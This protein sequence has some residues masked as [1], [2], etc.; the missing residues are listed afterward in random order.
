MPTDQ[1]EYLSA[2]GLLLSFILWLTAYRRVH[3][4]DKE[5]NEVLPW[6]KVLELVNEFLTSVKA[7]GEIYF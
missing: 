3:V 2:Q 1:F 5:N 7:A 6:N 4:S